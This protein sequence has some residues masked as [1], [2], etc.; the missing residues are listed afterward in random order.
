MADGRASGFWTD[1]AERNIRDGVDID[2]RLAAVDRQADPAAGSGGGD[3]GLYP[4]HGSGGNA[5]RT[6]PGAPAGL[7]ATGPDPD[8]LHDRR[9]DAVHPRDRQ[10]R[11]GGGDP[12]AI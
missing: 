1:Y 9:G 3:L 7:G 6:G 12:A 4:V 11:A 2:D 10:P 8:P 5:G